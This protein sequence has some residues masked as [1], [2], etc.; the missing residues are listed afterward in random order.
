MAKVPEDRRTKVKHLKTK[1]VGAIAKV[2]TTNYCSVQF[3]KGGF[4]TVCL[5]DDL[6]PVDEDEFARKFK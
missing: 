5:M 6:E 3:R 2:L 1:Q 4:Y